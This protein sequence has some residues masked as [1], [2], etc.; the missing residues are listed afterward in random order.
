MQKTL[1]FMLLATL[2]TT[3]RADWSML[4]D[5]DSEYVYVDAD[6]IV[7]NGSTAKLWELVNYKT[8]RT[9]ETGDAYVSARTQQEFDC[10]AQR[11]RILSYSFHRDAMAEDEAVYADTDIGDWQPIMPGGLAA[12]KWQMAC[13]KQSQ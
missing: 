11:F 9:D 2:C 4:E 7:K 1:W 8:T 6:N 12:A 5:N 3:A 10:T 13:G